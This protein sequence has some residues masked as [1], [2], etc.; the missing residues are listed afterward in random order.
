MNF[1]LVF[2]KKKAFSAHS[3]SIVYIFYVAKSFYFVPQSQVEDK[4]PK[5][6]S[7]LA[8]MKQMYLWTL[9][10]VRLNCTYLVSGGYG[11][12]MQPGVFHGYPLTSPK[13]LSLIYTAAVFTVH[14]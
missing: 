2:P 10:W 8:E 11:G 4:S 7:F 1:V 12:Q 13:G 5:E 9:F 14:F 3:Y 6:V